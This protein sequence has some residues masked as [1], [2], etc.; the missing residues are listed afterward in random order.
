MI[1][2]DGWKN[3]LADGPVVYTRIKNQVGPW[4]HS[5]RLTFSW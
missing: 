2:P 3:P 5:L 4:E 1:Q